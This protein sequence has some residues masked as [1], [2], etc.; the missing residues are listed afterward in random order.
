MSPLKTLKIKKRYLVHSAIFSVLL[1]IMLLYSTITTAQFV[2][3]PILQ[4]T[5]KNGAKP[6]VE[7]FKKLIRCKKGEKAVQSG[8]EGAV[9]VEVSNLQIGTQR[10]W[11][12]RQ[13]TGS[14]TAST[15]VYPVKA[16]YTV[17]TIY[18][19]ATEVEEGWIRILNFYVNS[20]GEWQIGS[21]EPVQAPKTKRI[22]K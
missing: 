15:L 22:P 6:D 21:E 4:K 17:K 10:P 7:L 12:Y 3:C 14:G 13:D 20:F 18:R 16:T 19:A 9:L 5:V 2:E 11:S 8:E 1:T